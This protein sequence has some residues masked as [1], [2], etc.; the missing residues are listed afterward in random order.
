MYI[1]LYVDDFLVVCKQESHI[2]EVEMEL[3]K[4]L[5]ITKLGDVS[6]FLGIRVDKDQEGFYNLSQAV[7][8]K[9]VA[10][11]FGLNDAK[12]SKFPMDTGYFKIRLD[13]KPLPNNAEYQRLIGSLLYIATHSRPDI[14]ACVGILS[15]KVSSPTLVDWTEARR[16]VRYLLQ[17]IDYGL[18]LGAPGAEFKLVGYCDSDWAGDSTDRKSCSGYLYRIGGAT[19]SW[20]SRKQS[21]V[22]TS[23]MEAEY[24]ALSGAAQEAVWLRGLL[25]ELDE[26]QVQATTVYEDNR[27]CLD[28]VA[29]DHQKKRSKHIDIRYHYTRDVCATG[30]IDLQYCTSEDMIADILTKP[31]GAER[32]RKFAA[33]MG[34]VPIPGR[35]G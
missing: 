18:R 31:L 27:S 33:M 7:F 32:V 2:K 17:T 21:C 25:D 11:S 6:C 26:K 8:I 1:L 9:K 20:I 30:V 3:Q 15:R 4:K 28:F 16:V 13:S 29:L 35:D 24:V 23:T 19:V 34:L 10:G 5:K 12:G 22:A 14:A